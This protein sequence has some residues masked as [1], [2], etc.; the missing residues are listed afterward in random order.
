MIGGRSRAAQRSMDSYNRNKIKVYRRRILNAVAKG[1]CVWEQTITNPK[2]EW[3]EEEVAMLRRCLK[4]RRDRYLMNPED[5]T[6]VRD[7]RYRIRAR[8]LA[9]LE[10]LRQKLYNVMTSTNDNELKGMIK[11]DVLK[12]VND[13]IRSN[14]VKTVTNTTQN[15][16]ALLQQ[17][18]RSPSNSPPATNVRQSPTNNVEQSPTNN[19]GQSPTNNVGHNTTNNIP[20]PSP[21]SSFV[22]AK[23]NTNTNTPVSIRPPTSSRPQ[24]II[25]DDRETITVQDVIDAYVFMI[26]T[27]TLC[28]NRN[29]FTK[30]KCKRE[31]ERD[32]RRYFD[33]LQ[34]VNREVAND[35]TYVYKNPMEFSS[36]T[37][38]NKHLLAMLYRVYMFSEQKRFIA[39]RV[40]NGL[41]TLATRV[42]S[43]RLFMNQFSIL[44]DQAKEAEITRMKQAPY[45]DWDDVKRVLS[46]VKG[47]SMRANFDRILISLY[48]RE[49]V[50]RDNLGLLRL[51]ETPPTVDNN[52][53]DNYI[54]K[55][56]DTERYVIVLKDFKNVAFRGSTQIQLHTDTSEIIDRY[57]IQMKKHLKDKRMDYLLTKSNGEP[58]ANGKLSGYIIDMFKRY[59]GVLNLGINEL[60]HSVAT[61][62]KDQSI[63]FKAELAFRMQHSLTQH[64]KYERYSNKVIKMPVFAAQG[65]S[66]SKDPFEG[67][68]IKM[69][70]NKKLVEGVVQ[71][72]DQG[73]SN[74]PYK[75]VFDDP[76]MVNKTFSS[77]MIA[78]MLEN[79]N[80][81][82]NIGKRVKYNVLPTDISVFGKPDLTGVISWND[83]YT[84][85][86][87]NVAPYAIVFDDDDILQKIVFDLPHPQIE[88]V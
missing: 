83:N 56:S 34:S 78:L 18:F 41:V 60:R 14:E 11:N 24:T 69:I 50:V 23:S 12:F 13:E 8:E 58:Y 5:I 31:Y 47:S 28:V 71:I 57:I 15:N 52:Q 44:Q 72:S 26:D 63:E 6:V 75:V 43:I 62:Y 29:A 81:I 16:A 73:P 70:V 10:S 17:P 87:D 49:N 76:S 22:S 67:R 19:V 33:I 54:Y 84:W 85:G 3:N 39:G 20:T 21:S 4:L 45:Y 48:V 9:V 42:K 37:K 1:R 59:T 53:Q 55:M 27:N 25:M 40:A 36:V 88:I 46:L 68:K 66:V 38:T 79:Q 86:D 35:I 77:T 74:H 61:Y 80:M 2:Y 64:K 65:A 51:Y 82:T 7:K 32:I 30:E